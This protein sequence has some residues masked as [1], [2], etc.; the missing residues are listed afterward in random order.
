MGESE[1]DHDTEQI[2]EK[3]EVCMESVKEYV[4]KQLQ[5]EIER[6]NALQIAIDEYKAKEKETMDAMDDGKI[7]SD[8]DEI[9]QLRQQIEALKQQQNGTDNQTQS[10]R[11]NVSNELAKQTK[12]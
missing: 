6:N 7:Q 10:D 4:F 8:K 3:N 2:N 12:K 1:S 11:A 5:Q 9:V